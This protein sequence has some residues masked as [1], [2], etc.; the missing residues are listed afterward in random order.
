MNISYFPITQRLQD[1]TEKVSMESLFQLDESIQLTE[2]PSSSRSEPKG[3]NNPNSSF[4]NSSKRKAA[5][6][7]NYS[8]VDCFLRYCLCF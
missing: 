5:G 4:A 1:E 8:I 3:T 6:S 7:E 2:N